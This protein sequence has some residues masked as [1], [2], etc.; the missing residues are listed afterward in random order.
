[1][2]ITVDSS[3]LYGSTDLYTGNVQ[4]HSNYEEETSIDAECP[5]CMPAGGTYDLSDGTRKCDPTPF[6]GGATA[7]NLGNTDISYHY[8]AR[9]YGDYLYYI[10]G[11]YID[12]TTI[13]YTLTRRHLPT[14]DE[15]SFVNDP[16][17]TYYWWYPRFGWGCNCNT[18]DVYMYG[19]TYNEDPGTDNDKCGIFKIDVVGSSQT[20]M[21]EWNISYEMPEGVFVNWF[22]ND[23]WI[24]VENNGDQV[25]L[26]KVELGSKWYD[27]SYNTQ[28]FA[29]Y[30]W[31]DVGQASPSWSSAEY[32]LLPEVADNP[33]SAWCYAQSP[34]Y[35]KSRKKIAHS[36]TTD[37]PPAEG[38]K[39]PI[40]IITVDGTVPIPVQE[41]WVTSLDSGAL[42]SYWIGADDVNGYIYVELRG[43][44]VYTQR[45]TMRIDIDNPA[46]RDV[47]LS[48]SGNHTFYKQYGT[49]LVR[50][51][52]VGDNEFHNEN[53]GLLFTVNGGN[54]DD[55][56]KY[57]IIS[58][59]FSR[60]S[61]IPIDDTL[62]YIWYYTYNNV[63]GRK[64]MVGLDPNTGTVQTYFDITGLTETGGGTI[65]RAYFV[66]PD[67]MIWYETGTTPFPGWNKVWLL[68][69][70]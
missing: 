29:R 41:L 21:V 54:F 65:G 48:K 42:G 32:N 40:H 43:Y 44:P 2:T 37:L 26:I 18:G 15:V 19:K 10:I 4:V 64:R 63:L 47:I 13:V 70:S 16:R 56:Y 36:F 57:S 52:T 24:W 17:V 58:G 34:A 1:M 46:T 31:A 38:G 9:R 66:G 8:F 22:Q 5:V 12:S 55:E 67:A 69:P 60:V 20:V 39:L 45:S 27:G 30:H 59:S 23:G 11:D 53:G 51:L 7:T 50:I 3:R 62:G 68:R 61:S 49:G 35:F 25:L 28:Q 33:D 6:A 14:G